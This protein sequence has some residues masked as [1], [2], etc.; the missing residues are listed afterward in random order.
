M[1]FNRTITEDEMDAEAREFVQGLREDPP[2]RDHEFDQD[3]ADGT[4][5]SRILSTFTG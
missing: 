5:G 3:L 1:P 4:L 2:E